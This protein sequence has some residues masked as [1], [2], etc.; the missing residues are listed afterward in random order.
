MKIINGIL[1]HI[2][3]I[4]KLI[5]LWTNL[6]IIS[7]VPKYII[8]LNIFRSWQKLHIGF[9]THKVGVAVLGKPSGSP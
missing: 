4:L 6:V 5:S 1:I 2:C 7:L 8:Q 9:L 3:F